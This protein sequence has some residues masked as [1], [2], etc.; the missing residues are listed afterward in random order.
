MFGRLSGFFYNTIREFVF[1][2]DIIKR[3]YDSLFLFIKNISSDSSLEQK[4]NLEYH[5]III[6]SNRT[7]EFKS[8]NLEKY[9]YNYDFIIVTNSKKEKLLFFDNKNELSSLID[10]YRNNEI[11]I[12][13]NSS[14]L[15][16]SFIAKVDNKDYEIVL[17]N[18][19]YNYFIV[20]N[21]IGNKKFIY[22]YLKSTYNIDLPCIDRFEPSF[23]LIDDMAD[24]KEN[25][26]CESLILSKDSYNL[27]I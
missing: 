11:D 3:K 13:D 2:F 24:I 7:F 20:N 14:E 16:L 23:T 1:L 5:F 12:F 22:W 15:F 25:I 27:I 17:K 19:D 4:N 6:N 9:T 8:E 10:K 18:N 26:I 21:D